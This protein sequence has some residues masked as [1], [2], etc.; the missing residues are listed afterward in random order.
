[1]VLNQGKLKIQNQWDEVKLG[2]ISNWKVAATVVARVCDE[3]VLN[4]GQVDAT[5]H[6]RF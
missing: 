6:H 4:T 3:T 2:P 5:I 1:M